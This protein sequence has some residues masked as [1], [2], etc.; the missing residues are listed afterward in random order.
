M[1]RKE[2]CSVTLSQLMSAGGE[3]SNVDHAG[4]IF[5]P[6]GKLTGSADK[7]L[8]T[9]RAMPLFNM[10]VDIVYF[11]FPP[12]GQSE[13]VFGRTKFVYN[14]GGPL[15][16]INRGEA[17]A[18]GNKWHLQKLQDAVLFAN[19]VDAAVDHDPRHDAIMQ[20]LMTHVQGM[21]DIVRE[22][23]T[24]DVA[25]IEATIAQYPAFTENSA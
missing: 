3:L 11:F 10:G 21:A 9:L 19:L 1:K 18:P 7:G 13:V 15:G 16:W 25:A 2:E 14:C 4:D 12:D 6:I 8:F 5:G 20:T 22:T 17:Y 23:C 24:K